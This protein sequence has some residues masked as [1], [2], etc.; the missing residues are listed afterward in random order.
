MPKV[1]RNKQ[2]TDFSLLL[3]ELQEKDKDTGNTTLTSSTK[4]LPTSNGISRN[5]NTALSN[6]EI[7]FA[8]VTSGKKQ[9]LHD[10]TCKQLKEIAD[11]KIKFIKAF[12][13]QQYSICN[14]CHLLICLRI[15]AKDKN[16]GKEYKTFFKKAN[17]TNG[18]IFKTYI[19]YKLQTRIQ[20]EST[21][22]VWSK[23]DTWKIEIT[24]QYGDVILWHNN[25]YIAKYS[26]SYHIEQKELEKIE[27]SILIVIHHLKQEEKQRSTIIGAFLY[28]IKLT[29]YTNGYHSHSKLK[30]TI[31]EFHIVRT[32]NETPNE[33][34]RYCI[35]YK[36]NTV[37][38]YNIGIFDTQKQSFTKSYSK[39]LITNIANVVAWK[40]L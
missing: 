29:L 20:N 32:P 6:P 15:G 5:R 35:V 39:D 28:R 18:L 1:N 14:V 31:Q 19:D 2:H 7:Q 22:I 34:G 33:N 40:K 26:P 10:K 16:K 3:S 30:Q 12:P 9:T 36:S 24:S 17:A 25:Y 4:A 21:I 37:Y 27:P 13:Q 38:A 11:E 8:I 23:E